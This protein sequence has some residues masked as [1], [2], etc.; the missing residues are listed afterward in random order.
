MTGFDL[1]KRYSRALAVAL[2]TFCIAL[3]LT[4]VVVPVVQSV[5]D[6]NRETEES[7]NRYNRYR[8]VLAAKA[9]LEQSLATV[10]SQNLESYLYSS[11]GAA[12]NPAVAL[13]IVQG[14]ARR[15]IESNGGKID[16]NMAL[17]AKEEGAY[18]RLGSKMEFGASVKNL[19]RILYGLEAAHPLLRTDAIHIFTDQNQPADQ[20]PLLRVRMTVY[21]YMRGAA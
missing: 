9:T 2:L 13:S 6:L 19:A 11:N 1:N 5:S 14:D 17:D 12:N 10:N 15:I 20:E 21:G 7:L 4:L 18:R 3:L 16:T 8:S